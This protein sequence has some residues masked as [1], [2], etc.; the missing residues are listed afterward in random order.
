MEAR[1]IPVTGAG[2]GFGGAT[3]LHAVDADANAAGRDEA[4]R[5]R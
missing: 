4:A 3:V 1:A 5:A 2:G